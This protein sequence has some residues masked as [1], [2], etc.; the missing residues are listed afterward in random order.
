[1]V[2]SLMLQPYLTDAIAYLPLR[3]FDP[4]KANADV[5]QNLREALE[6]HRLPGDVRSHYDYR[7]LQLP[8]A[9]AR[10]VFRLVAYGVPYDVSHSDAS[11]ITS[12][13]AAKAVA[14]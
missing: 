10:Y 12:E 14:E 8:E 6:R 2:Q 11:L 7:Y 5:C 4:A 13:S 9:L 1:M 3:M